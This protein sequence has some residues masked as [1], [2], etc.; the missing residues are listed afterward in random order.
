MRPGVPDRLEQAP[1]AH[2]VE[3]LD[4]EEGGEAQ[5]APAVPA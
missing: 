2:V 4:T 3:P 5:G 1:E